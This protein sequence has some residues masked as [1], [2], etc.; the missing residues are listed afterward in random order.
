VASSEI[1]WDLLCA[2]QILEFVGMGLE[3]VIG[4]AMPNGPKT[5]SLPISM[6]FEYIVRFAFIKM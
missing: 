4:A 5:K 3:V 1:S 6:K 2:N